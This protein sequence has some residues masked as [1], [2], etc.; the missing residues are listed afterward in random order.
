MNRGW[1]TKKIDLLQHTQEYN[2][3][4]TVLPLKIVSGPFN[5]VKECRPTEI[6]K[7]LRDFGVIHDYACVN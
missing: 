3:F 5:S 2:N 7:E 1:G 6:F 4:T